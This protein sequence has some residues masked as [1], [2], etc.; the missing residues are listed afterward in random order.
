[1]AKATKAK[2][3]SRAKQEKPAKAGKGKR[4]AGKPKGGAMAKA[5]KAVKKAAKA[6]TKAVK[7]VAKKLK[8]A[9]KAA[10]PAAQK[11]QEQPAAPPAPQPG[12]GSVVHV[13]FYTPDIDAAKTFWGELLG[14]EFHP[15]GPNE[16][17]FHGKSGWGPGGCL[18]RGEPNCTGAPSIY[19]QVLDI[20][21]MLQRAGNLGATQVKDKTEIP[22]NH[23]FYAHFRT[24]DGNQFGI[25]S[26]K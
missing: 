25:W 10:K 2:A 20:P 22:G 3:K 26:A 18:V 21:A 19:F 13:E 14:L 17:Y 1:M 7:T 16:Y 8:H 23:G 11:A 9:A 15:M 24:A 5:R 6:A 4:A 12:T